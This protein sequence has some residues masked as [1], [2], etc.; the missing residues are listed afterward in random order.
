MAQRCQ[1]VSPPVRAA[2]GACMK[3]GRASASTAAGAAAGA[4]ARPAGMIA[5]AAGIVTAPGIEGPS[6]TMPRM[7]RSSSTVRG[8]SAAFADMQRST[9]VIRDSL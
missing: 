6:E 7:W 5:G 3:E 4:G 9:A 1:R 8:R 2:A